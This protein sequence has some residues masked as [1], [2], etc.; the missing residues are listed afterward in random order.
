MAQSKKK[1]VQADGLMNPTKLK[2]FTKK[3]EEST[4]G[5]AES[6]DKVAADHHRNAEGMPKQVQLRCGA[7]D[8]CVEDGVTFRDGVSV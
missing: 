5:T 1:S 6:G 4:T 8:F 3:A 7:E 2:P